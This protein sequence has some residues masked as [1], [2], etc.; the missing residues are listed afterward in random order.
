MAIGGGVFVF[1]V[2]GFFYFRQKDKEIERAIK[3]EI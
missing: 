1:G 2:L 3:G